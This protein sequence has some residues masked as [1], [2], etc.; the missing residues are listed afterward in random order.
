VLESTEELRI[1][2]WYKKRARI[3]DTYR[4]GLVYGTKEF[5][6]RYKSH[7]RVKARDFHV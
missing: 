5:R 7:R 3:I 6:E 2:K 1:S 4:G